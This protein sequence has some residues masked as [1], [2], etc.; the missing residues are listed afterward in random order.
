MIKVGSSYIRKFQF[1]EAVSGVKPSI[2]EHTSSSPSNSE[3]ESIENKEKEKP[4]NTEEDYSININDINIS[5]P[6]QMQIYNDIQ[7]LFPDNPIVIL[8][9]RLDF[10]ATNKIEL[11]N[12]ILSML[13]EVDTK[14]YKD[15]Y[16]FY[17]S[18]LEAL[19]DIVEKHPVSMDNIVELVQAAI[20]LF[21]YTGGYGTALIAIY[22]EIQKRHLTKEEIE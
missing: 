15:A 12:E 17:K 1:F 4:E 21:D 2:E 8:P 14:K 19:F 11:Q 5:D 22:R 18:E 7:K 20:P 9:N 13:N 16:Y 6:R 10:R 3:D